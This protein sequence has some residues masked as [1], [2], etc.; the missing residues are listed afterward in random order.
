MLKGGLEQGEE[1]GRESGSETIEHL[2]I[3]VYRRPAKGR[4][5]IVPVLMCGGAGS[6]LWPLSNETTPKQFHAFAGDRSM[7]QLTL[8][9]LYAEG[10]EELCAPIIVTGERYVDLVRAQLAELG[11]EALRIVLEPMGRNT[12]PVAVIASLLAREHAPGARV[13]LLPADHII[14]EPERLYEL[15]QDAAGLEDRIITFGVRPDR[16]ET[17][18]GYIRRGRRLEGEVYEIERF[19][20]KPDLARAEAFVKD[21][22]FCWNA[23][24]FLFPPNLLLAEMGAYQPEVLSAAEAA[25]QAGR[26]EGPVVLLDAERFAA[27]PSISIDYAVMEKTR[28]AAVAACDVPW[29]DVGSWQE[30]WRLGPADPRGNVARGEALIVD[31]DNCLVHATSRR[32]AVLG[33]TD[34][35]VVETPDAVLV[36]PIDR[37][38]D[39]KTVVE[40]LAA[41]TAASALK[42]LA[43]NDDEAR[44]AE[45]TGEVSAHG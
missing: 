24:F 33:L 44:P 19:T 20:E 2:D 30:L 14:G 34:V 39:V 1:A 3:D 13:L 26:S 11:L 25:L 40:A 10:R 5:P 21:P 22:E 15:I 42:V 45:A 38:Q 41:A 9:R 18:Y 16:P 7:F 29:S 32:V 6:R 17:G 43:S 36:L 35:V 28:K 23:G 27:C 8:E 4:S 12:A 37:S 31:S